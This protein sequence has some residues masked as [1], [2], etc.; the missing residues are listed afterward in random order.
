[1]NAGKWQDPVMLM[2]IAPTLKAV[3]SAL[4]RVGTLEMAYSAQAQTVSYT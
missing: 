1:M 2:L 3:M 4:A